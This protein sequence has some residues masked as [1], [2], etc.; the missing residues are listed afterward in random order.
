MTDFTG[1]DP[2]TAIVMTRYLDWYALKDGGRKAKPPFILLKLNHPDKNYLEK[3]MKIKV[4]AY[5]VG[6]D[7]G[8]TWTHFQKI[9][10]LN[11][12]PGEDYIQRYLETSL[13]SPGFGG[14]MFCTYELYGK[15]AKE[16]RQQLYLW[17]FCM[18][19][20]VKQGILQEG[21]G[22]SV[23]VVLVSVPSGHGEMIETHF[24]PVDGEDYGNSI[25]KIFPPKY[26]KAIF[27]EGGDYNRRA[28]ALQRAAREKAR[29]YNHV[30]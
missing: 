19:Y 29:I 20:Y 14:K 18:E 10:I 4:I 16:D 13:E 30:E 3:G 22:V 27:A 6:G 8:G 9:V 28:Q 15:E 21:T 2:E 17:A 7:E 24:Q 1:V 23:P 12:N 25:R 5:T 11:K 26:H